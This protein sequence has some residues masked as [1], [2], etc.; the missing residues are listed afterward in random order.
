M[1]LRAIMS[2][3]ES[4]VEVVQGLSQGDKHVPVIELEGKI[5]VLCA[6]KS[7][8]SLTNDKI[9]LS[10]VRWNKAGIYLYKL[11]VLELGMIIE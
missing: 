10:I 4:L 2:G 8:V 5:D 6:Y 3:W 7:I 1:N 9:L 11:I